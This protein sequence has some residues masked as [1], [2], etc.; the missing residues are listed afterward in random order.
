VYQAGFGS[1]AAAR[2]AG[3]EHEPIEYAL[4]AV[5]QTI[6]SILEA[7]GAEEYVVFL[8]SP[9]NYRDEI[10][11]EY[12][13]NRDSA[14]RPYWYSE[15]REY[16]LDKH[17]AQYAD[18]GDEADD[19]MGIFQMEALMRDEETIICTIDKDL[20]LIPGLHYNFSKNNRQRG[21]FEMDDPQC[22]RMF[23]L[24]MLTGDSTDNIPGMYRKLGIKASKAHK[25]PIL[26]MTRERDMLNYVRDIYQDD[27]FVRLIGNLLWIKRERG[28]SGWWTSRGLL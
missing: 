8:S 6:N 7:A 18:E 27:A 21:V 22:L 16:L 11:P 26:E 19:A 23:Y 25:A 17:G 28:E 2:K 24:Q 14:H 10:F 12:K 1:D 5:K 9:F 13:A 3:Y 15:I 20:Q 4:N